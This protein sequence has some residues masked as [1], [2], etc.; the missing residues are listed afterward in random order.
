VGNSIDLP[1]A[2]SYIETL[3]GVGI[4]VATISAA[5]LPAHQSDPRIFILGGQHSPEGVGT[6]VTGLMTQK[7]REDTLRPG[8]KTLVVLPSI[9][10]QR[11]MVQI[12]AG[13]GKEQ[14]RKLF[15][16]AQGDIIKSIRFNESAYPQNYT[17]STTDVPQLDDTQPY[18]EVDAYQ[19]NAIIGSL[20]GL[21]IIDVRGV[22]FYAS[23][24]IPGAVNIQAVKVGD[25]L[26]ELPRDRTYLLYCGGNSE[27]ISA[28]NQLAANGYKKLYR[29]V[30]GYMAWRMAGFPK[31]K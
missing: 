4:D 13:Y 7:E 18:T 5:E 20:P 22:P 6:I 11:Q 8:A 29:L 1:F 24:H 26:S 16:E 19:A 27:S 12:F 3:R 31:A 25:H 2:A 15:A 23:G 9:W 14:T 17:L 28:A 30:D 10:A 21:E